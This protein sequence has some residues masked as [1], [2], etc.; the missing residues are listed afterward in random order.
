[1]AQTKQ[2]SKQALA[3]I[4]S[5][6]S[7]GYT[8]RA[9]AEELTKQGFVTTNGKKYN[10]HTAAGLVSYHSRKEKFKSLSKPRELV[11]KIVRILSSDFTNEDK[12]RFICSLLDG[13]ENVN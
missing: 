3:I 5:L 10:S 13:G 9:C 2:S 8:F 11:D 1:M 4:N 6:R 12:A 7:Q